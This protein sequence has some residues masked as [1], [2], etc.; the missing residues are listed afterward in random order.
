MK[1][2]FGNAITTVTTLM[3]FALLGFIGWSVVNRSSIQYWGRRSTVLLV[4]GLVICCFAA[5]RDGLD[6]TIQHAIDGSCAPGL[7]PL[8]SVPT[9]VG[10]V[11]A[12]LIIVAAIATPIAKTQKMREAWF[13]V[14]SSGVVLK[15]VTMEIAR[16]IF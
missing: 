9:I 15:I 7:F 2:Y 10:C 13:Y 3:L 12:L 16:I 4:F 14:M 6:K 1:L 5:A 8:I 11:G